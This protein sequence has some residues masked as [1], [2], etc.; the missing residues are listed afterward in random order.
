MITVVLCV[1]FLAAAVVSTGIAVVAWRRRRTAAGFGATAFLNTGLAGWASTDAIEMTLRDGRLFHATA[2]I[3]FVFVCTVVVGWLVMSYALA[4]RTWH[5]S[6]RFIALISIEPALCVLAVATNP[7]HLQFFV[8][9]Q[10]TGFDG[11]LVPVYGPMF[12]AHSAYSYAVLGFAFVR[13]VRLWSITSS[14][15]QAAA[16]AVL[17]SL[18][19]ALLNMLVLALHGRLTDLTALGFALTAPLMY[20]M[21]VRESMPAQAPVAHR[22]IFEKIS[23]AVAVVGRDGRILDINPAGEA[24]LRQ[25]NAA[26]PDDLIGLTMADVLGPA[27]PLMPGRD[28]LVDDDRERTVENAQGS[29]LDVDIR[30][31][32]LNGRGDRCIGWAIVTRDVT[33]LNRQRREL[34]HQLRTIELLRADLAEQA[35]RD[36]LTGLHNRRHLM[37]GLT[38]AVAAG[39]TLSVALIDIDH[40]KS[41]NDGYG[42][43]AGDAVLIRIATLLSGATRPGELCARY[44]GE[45]FVLVL[46]GPDAVSR[47]DALRDRVATTPIDLGDGRTVTVTFSAGVATRTG[48]ETPER[49]LESADTALYAAK[50][51]GRNRVTA[52]PH[53]LALPHLPKR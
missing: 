12:W 36:H 11:G 21:V 32:R 44:G 45:E 10:N 51:A 9:L 50:H 23:D 31:S 37:S 39:G 24:L 34:E 20:W 48:P 4:D 47:I 43:A 3:S 53:S 1:L 38:R 27:T 8:G 52:A 46:T 41:I 30:V 26:S 28:L 5:P 29:G 13:V 17:I 35:V 6:R 16:F 15:Y 25:L 22:R 42:H 40:F 14:R 18:P 19:S 2:T 33:D 49:L 7:W